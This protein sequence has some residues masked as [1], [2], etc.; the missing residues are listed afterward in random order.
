MTRNDD[1][2]Q[3]TTVKPALQRCLYNSH[4]V[5]ND[6]DIRVSND[7]DATVTGQAARLDNSAAGCSVGGQQVSLQTTAG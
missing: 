7:V 5:N 3:T 4:L 2:Q 6:M 1:R